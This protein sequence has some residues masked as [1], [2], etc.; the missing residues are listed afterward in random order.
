M[1]YN[2]HRRPTLRQEHKGKIIDAFVSSPHLISFVLELSL[3]DLS[4]LIGYEWKKLSE[5]Q[6]A[7]SNHR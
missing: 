7:V 6:K 1:L 3:P 4:K 2:N 5:N